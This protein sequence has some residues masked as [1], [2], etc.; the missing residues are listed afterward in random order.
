MINDAYIHTHRVIII[1]AV[2]LIHYRYR[3]RP[4]EVCG[5]SSDR[6][7]IHNL[8]VVSGLGHRL[9]T[10]YWCHRSVIRSE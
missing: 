9:K 8:C 4:R 7:S 3:L 2:L 5:V 6:I 1:L 10:L